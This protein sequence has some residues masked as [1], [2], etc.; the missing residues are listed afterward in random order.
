MGQSGE[1]LHLL[2]RSFSCYG[3]CCSLC[4]LFD[5]FIQLDGKTACLLAYRCEWASQTASCCTQKNSAIPLSCTV[6]ST[7]TTSWESSRQ[8]S[9]SLELLQGAGMHG[10][11]FALMRLA[12]HD[13]HAPLF[14]WWLKVPGLKSVRLRAANGLLCWVHLPCAL[15]SMAMM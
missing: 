13:A 5:G 14:A 15:P 8:T 1:L 7:D 10:C 12:Q 3:Q 9:E 6:A 11:A 2:S 4:S